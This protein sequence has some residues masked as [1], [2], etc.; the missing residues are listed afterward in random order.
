MQQNQKEKNAVNYFLLGLVLSGTAIATYCAY[1]SEP[2]I[3]SRKSR[4]TQTTTAF[5]GIRNMRNYDT[6]DNLKL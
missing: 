5:D 2:E 4:I 3:E 6:L 1:A